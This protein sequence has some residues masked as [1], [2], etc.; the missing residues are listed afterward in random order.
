MG[1]PLIIE[2]GLQ[3]DQLAFG[4]YNMV[5]KATMSIQNV[6]DHKKRKKKSKINTDS[7][8]AK[9]VNLLSHQLVFENDPQ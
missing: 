9:P 7:K 2:S 4:F 1:D 3:H 6:S 8:S 5:L